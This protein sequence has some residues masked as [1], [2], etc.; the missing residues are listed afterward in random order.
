[1]GSCSS[2]TLSELGEILVTPGLLGDLK[3]QR[4]LNFDGGSSSAFW[5][6][7]KGSPFSIGEYKTVRNFV[8]IAPK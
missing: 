4:A 5:F 6:A 7:G 3:V 8:V 1:M 2:A